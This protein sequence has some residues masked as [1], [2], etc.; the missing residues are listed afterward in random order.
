MV[1]V[2][3]ATVKSCA[4]GVLTAVGLAGGF[5]WTTHAQQRGAAAGTVAIDADDIGGVVTGPKGPEAGVWVVAETTDTPTRFIRSVVTDD[6]GRYVVPDLPRGKYQVFVRGY[7]LVDS[8]KVAGAPGQQLNLRAVPAPD[9]RAAAQIY[10]AAYW[11]SLMEIPKGAM[12]EREVLSAVKECLTCH[13][14]GNQGTRE[15]SKALGTFPNSLAAWDHRVTVGP[16]GL[17]M[18]GSFQ[19]F[20]EQRR[21]FA[22]WTDKIAAGACRRRCRPGRPGSSATSS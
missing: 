22:E 5:T 8:P 13:Q 15:I 21:M 7:G 14:V 12:P 16:M 19:R 10:P 3:T 6:Q 4:L 20:G 18:S 11:L 17:A 2:K 9:A 1:R